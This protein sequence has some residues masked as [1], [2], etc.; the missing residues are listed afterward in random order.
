MGYAVLHL[1]KAS[2]N[3]TKMTAHIERTQMPKNADP[4]RT[5]LN[6][7]L[8]EFPEGV[9][10]RTQAINYRLDN[11]ELERKIGKNQ[12]RVIRVMLTGSHEDM[13]RIQDSGKLD[14]WCN[15]NLDWLRKT[16]GADNL[17][18]AVL[19]MDE[20]TPHIHASVVPIVTGERRKK[21]PKPDE[22][23]KKQYRKKSADSARLCADDVMTASKLKGYQDSYAEAMAK[24]GLQRGIVGSEARHITTQEFYRNVVA[25]Q[26]NLQENI[27]LLLQT[28][29]A[30]R[31]TIE[32]LKQLEQQAL[33]QTEMAVASQKQAEYEL[34]EKQSELEK[35][36]G[37][38]KTEK[39][40]DAAADVGTK[41][42]NFVGS[43]FGTSKIERQQQE[44]EELKQ[45][46]MTLEMQLK[47]REVDF[48]KLRQE[49]QNEIDELNQT[50][51]IE[52]ATKQNEIGCIV[53]WFPD[54]PEMAKTADY[55]MD[56]GF[57]HD[58][59]IDLLMRKPVLYNGKLRSPKTKRSYEAENVRARLEKQPGKL[60]IILTIDGISIIQWFKQQYEMIKEKLDRT[61][62]PTK[63]RGIS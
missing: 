37:E 9:T 63:S 30:K 24:Y 21:K 54:I 50:H 48:R 49:H 45:T 44:I 39:F 52:L 46:K 14:E 25:Q 10:N 56:I 12:V 16:Y 53:R 13:K 7:E 6:R 5:H 60:G 43:I 42:A 26:G 32:E 27:E 58:Q 11:A 47:N 33:S 8:I 40:K 51:K 3:E 35:I 28:E 41:A 29:D 31:K 61:P 18:S 19:H 20:S 36:K 55:C 62:K 2:G 38:L 22:P 15:D 23:P 1:D 17:V 57:S 59:T 34:T 4:T